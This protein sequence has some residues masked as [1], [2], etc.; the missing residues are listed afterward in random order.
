MDKTKKGI[1][2][3]KDEDSLVE[4]VPDDKM[5]ALIEGLANLKPVNLAEQKQAQSLAES[6]ILDT[7]NLVKSPE[8]LPRSKPLDNE[9]D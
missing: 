5:A 1:P 2:V 9:R 3:R 4:Q 7:D 6:S 8:D